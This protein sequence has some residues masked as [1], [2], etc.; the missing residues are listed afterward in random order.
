M[1]AQVIK[2]VID[3]Y[4]KK[5]TFFE[6]SQPKSGFT[7]IQIQSKNIIKNLPSTSIN[8]LEASSVSNILAYKLSE[9]G[10]SQ[11]ISNIFHEKNDITLRLTE[12]KLVYPE[13]TKNK[14]LIIKPSSPVSSNF[15]LISQNISF[16]Q[17]KFSFFLKSLESLPSNFSISKCLTDLESSIPLPQTDKLIYNM[18]KK[19]L[20]ARKVPK[21][22]DHLTILTFQETCKHSSNV[23]R[24]IIELSVF[25]SIINLN[26]KLLLEYP[27]HI[28]PSSLLILKSYFNF[29][30]KKTQSGRFL[31][32]DNIVQYTTSFHAFATT[33]INMSVYTMIQKDIIFSF[34]H[35]SQ[36]NLIFKPNNQF[37]LENY[38]IESNLETDE[39][40]LF[41]KIEM[42]LTPSEYAQEQRI[43]QL[44][45]KSTDLFFINRFQHKKISFSQNGVVSY[46]INTQA[47]DFESFA[48]EFPNV[49][50]ESVYSLIEEL[51]KY[52][53]NF[54][55]RKFPIQHFKWYEE[56]PIFM[57]F[58]PLCQVLEQVDN[59]G[60][61]K[62][63]KFCLDKGT[64]LDRSFE[65][66]SEIIENF[67]TQIIR[68]HLSSLE[69]RNFYY[70]LDEIL[71]ISKNSHF[72]SLPESIAK[73]RLNLYN[74][75]SSAG[76]RKYK[77]ICQIESK[78]LLICSKSFQFD[79]ASR[80]FIGDEILRVLG[81]LVNLI[82]NLTLKN[83][84]FACFDPNCLGFNS[85]GQLKIEIRVPEEVEFS[86]KPPEVLF[87]RSHRYSLV[88][89]FGKV[90]EYSFFI[91]RCTETG[92]FPDLA[93]KTIVIQEVYQNLPWLEYLIKGCTQEKVT[94]RWKIGAVQQYL[95][96]F[97]SL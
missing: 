62:K 95:N 2:S 87:G 91:Q 94:K 78:T 96:E 67:F 3:E 20:I 81:Q 59:G 76:I 44:L 52:N 92:L 79:F 40:A 93:N 51:K 50:I 34:S 90:A 22:E 66:A 38:I 47:E 39:N 15:L 7:I 12:N 6:S 16:K 97:C 84:F 29:I 13:L 83:T 73:G 64:D 8:V 46:Q 37:S 19:E 36:F 23:K 45:D 89:S 32:K 53:L 55:G 80:L 69:K 56:K 85:K 1:H 49:T 68:F 31:F 75:I 9:T 4:N 10:K 71:T 72:I 65:P 30:N 18:L 63:K 5:I 77:G 27:G 48:Q 21:F 74:S 26:F 86:F 58:V 70:T 57:Y 33:R 35:F 82:Q 28:T 17:Y 60:P 11:I 14:K 61:E 41:R 24:Q 88:Y 25:K 42:K 54:I 43:K